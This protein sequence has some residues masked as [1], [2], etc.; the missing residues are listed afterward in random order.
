MWRRKRKV[1]RKKRSRATG[2]PK[3]KASPQGKK[4]SAKKIYANPETE[5]IA[6][7][8]GEYSKMRKEYIAAKKEDGYTYPEAS[9]AWKG[10]DQRAQVLA[11]MTEGE[12]KRRRF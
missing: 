2:T 9:E 12:R 4:K 10:S 7:K 5:V 6:Y 1:K 8:A 3:K 11:G